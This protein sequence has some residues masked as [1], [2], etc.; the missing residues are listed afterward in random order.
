MPSCLGAKTRTAVWIVKQYAVTP[1]MPGNTRHFELARRMV[2]A[3]YDVTIFAAG[4]HYSR[5]EEH[6]ATG[7]R[8]WSTEHVS[9]V[10]LVW[11]KTPPFTRNDWRRVVH[12]L[13]F[14]FRV[15]QVGARFLGRLSP[16]SPPDL[17]LGCTA[18]PTAAFAAYLLSR[19]ARCPFCYEIGDTWPKALVEAGVVSK[20]NPLTV[21]LSWLDRFLIRK[22]A[23]IP[24]PLPGGAIYVAEQGGNAERVRWIPNGVTLDA[25]LGH[26]RGETRSKTSFMVVYVGILAS[27]TPLDTLLRA[28]ATLEQEIDDLRIEIVGDGPRKAHL[29]SLAESLGL[30]CVRFR[31]SVPRTEIPAILAEAAVGYYALRETASFRVYGVGGKKLSEYFAAGLPVVFAAS[32]MIDPVKKANCGISVPPYDVTAVAEALRTLYAL[33]EAE[34]LEMGRRGRRV[35]R[36]EYSW[37]VLAAR[38]GDV[39][40]E[41]VQQEGTRKH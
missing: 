26:A 25:W 31:P 40:L 18:P 39:L 19:R 20:W 16:F 7:K 24:T 38:L 33:S 8:I 36:D 15:W 32:T 2:R 28:A 41:V 35:A 11:I 5:R 30:T 14:S 3:G 21:A 22:A 29:E 6:R 13:A 37:D 34:R 4:F 23:L 12:M 9:G 17:V 10:R 27:V 1:D